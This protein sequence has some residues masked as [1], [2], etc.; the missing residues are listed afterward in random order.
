MEIFKN[1][2]MNY[3]DDDDRRIKEVGTG[4]FNYGAAE[5]FLTSEMEILQMSIASKTNELKFSNEKREK[6]NVC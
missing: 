4:L 6:F 1:E 5:F 3:G 2:I